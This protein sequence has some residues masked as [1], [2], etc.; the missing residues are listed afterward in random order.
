MSSIVG[1][2]EITLDCLVRFDNRSL[3][4]NKL[5]FGGNFLGKTFLRLVN[6][7]INRSL[8]PVTYPSQD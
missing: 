8:R 3:C 1:F 6:G 7:V 4:I 5:C 2:L